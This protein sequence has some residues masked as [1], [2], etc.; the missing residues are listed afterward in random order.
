MDAVFSVS[1]G[2]FECNFYSFGVKPRIDSILN[3]RNV[4]ISQW[5]LDAD[6]GIFV[7]RIHLAIS[8]DIFGF[9]NFELGC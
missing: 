1:T 7:S 3:Q 8:G 4:W 9:H 5:F 6:E 2:I